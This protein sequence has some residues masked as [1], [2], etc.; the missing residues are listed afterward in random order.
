[1]RFIR[2]L[3]NV[4]IC[5]VGLG[6]SGTNPGEVTGFNST[7]T[8]VETLK[9]EG[10]IDESMFGLFLAPVDSSTGIPKGQGEITFGGVDQS[11]IQGIPIHVI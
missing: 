1:M 8:F 9:S 2:W 6:P 4:A 3:S 5:S 11:K 7:P 10:T